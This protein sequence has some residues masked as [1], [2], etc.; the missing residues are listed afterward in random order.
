MKLSRLANII[1]ESPTLKLSAEAGRLKAQGQPVIH[2]GIGEPKNAAPPQAISSSIEKLKTGMVKYGPTDGLPSLKSAIMQYTEE[3]YGRRVEPGNIIVSN[4]AKHS[5][6]NI[7]YAIV[8]PGDEVILLAPYWVSYPE[9][10]KIV[11][12]NPVVVAPEEGTFIP[13][14]KGIE[15]VVSTN[16]K[17]IIMNSPNNPS[18]VVYPPSFVLDLVGFCEKEDIYL[19]ADDIYHQLV[20]D[21]IEASPVFLFTDKDVNNSNMIVVNGVSKLYG[22]T[23]FRIGWTVANRKLVEVMTNIQ[24]QV[25]SC[26]SIISQVAAE[27]ALTGDQGV[28]EELRLT[29]QHNR[30]IVVEK[31][32]EF[33]GVCLNKPLGTFYALPDFRGYNQNSH[34]LA[35]FILNKALV[36]TVPGS[37]FGMEGYLRISYAG[38]ERDIVEGIERMR[39]ALDPTY[40]DEIVIG[41]KKV[42]RD[43][44]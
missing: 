19:I 13:T 42:K 1:S 26:P 20:F 28:V 35:E 10:I 21:G 39:W 8:E 41:D 11:G 2:L 9:M 15:N 3:N 24:S 43:W 16:T 5:I 40:P 7:L 37:D 4:G 32:S 27:G 22:M 18:G 34:E 6:V 23:G 44:I 30:D 29:I 38:D 36:V 17:A 12:G 33:S 31:M 14:M 25:T